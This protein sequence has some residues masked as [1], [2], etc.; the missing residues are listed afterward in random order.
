MINQDGRQIH[1]LTHF[2][3]AVTAAAWNPR[4]DTFIIASQD[5]AAPLV[6]YDAQSLEQ[7]YVWKEDN[8]RVYDIAI[9]PDGSRLVA[10]LETRILVYDI[11]TRQKIGDYP[12]DDGRLTSVEISRD[13]MR[14]LVGLNEN[15]IK[16]FS[17]D[18][19]EPLQ[20][21]EGHK[22]KEY[23]IRS[24]FGGA[25]ET[26]VVSG[27]EGE[28]SAR[29]R[30]TSTANVVADSRVY[31]WRTTGQLVEA[32]EAHRP[33]CVNTV[34]WHPTEPAMFASAGDDMRVRM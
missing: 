25:Q 13:S 26:F 21:F 16:I 15:K 34:A 3:Y 22:Q 20:E 1:S 8:L 28:Y 14:M 4:N 19:G 23:M 32:L 6:L 10:L 11:T 17:I 31:I 24:A 7:L 12:V 5:S 18:N 9:S 29:R 33:G 2:T 27:S 30:R